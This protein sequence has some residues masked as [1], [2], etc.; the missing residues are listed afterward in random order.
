MQD[1]QGRR[2][3]E[4]WSDLCRR[5]DR[6][7]LVGMWL[8]G[9]AARQVEIRVYEL[10]GVLVRLSPWGFAPLRPGDLYVCPA[11]GVLRSFVGS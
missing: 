11:S 8:R 5:A 1:Q 6:R 9:D 10:D 2:W 7:T 3:D 4:V